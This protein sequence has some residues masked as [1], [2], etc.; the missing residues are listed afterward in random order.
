MSCT[1]EFNAQLFRADKS[2]VFVCFTG[3]WC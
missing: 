1:V 3:D 2:R